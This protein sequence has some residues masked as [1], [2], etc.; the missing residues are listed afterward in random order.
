MAATRDSAMSVVHD[1]IR[2]L[3]EV[4][5]GD[6]GGKLHGCFASTALSSFSAV[7]RDK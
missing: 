3:S 7:G 6:I 1:E 5:V 4:S 2:V